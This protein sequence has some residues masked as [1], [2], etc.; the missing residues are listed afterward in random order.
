ME[1][2]AVLQP[3]LEQR[4]KLAPQ[5][6]QS[7][8]ILQ[9]PTLELME[10]VETELE[11]N[12]VLEVREVQPDPDAR[13]EAI[14]SVESARED[15][16]QYERFNDV[17]DDW[18]DYFTRSA[19]PRAAGSDDEGL[20]IIQTAAARPKT[21]HDHLIEQLQLTEIDDELRDIVEAIIYHLDADGYLRV[22]L[23]EIVDGLDDPVPMAVA[24]DALAVIQSFEPPGLG[25]RDLKEC[26]LLQLDYTDPETPFLAE[27]ITNHLKDI[28][29]NRLPA[30]AKA[31]GKSID[32]VK[33]GIERIRTLNPEPGTVF[34][35][36]PAPY[37]VPDVRVEFVDGRYQV[38]MEDGR[39]PPL[40]ISQTY[41]SMMDDQKPG[42]QAREFLKKRFDSARWLI[43]AIEQRRNTLYRVA[44]KIVEFQQEFFDKG[45]AALKPLKMQEV[46][47]E[48][49][50]HVSTVSR[51]ISHKYML[52][53][54]G[55]SD[56]RSFFSGGTT[57][58]DGNMESWEAVRQKL[59]DIVGN[60][61]KKKPLSDEEI[62]ERL[63]AQGYNIARRTV[64][65]YRKALDIPSSRQRK[66]Y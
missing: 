23:E 40:Q 43:D 49:G 22:P 34:D 59:L 39:I 53:P 63:Q 4:M 19:S 33:E 44:C 57:S 12:P 41:R 24:E 32:E 48:L 8:E 58:A 5:I 42:S 31:T 61:D 56:L 18:R 20:D 7:I 35:D 11:E 10:R 1:M 54:Q 51:A 17:A 36:A 13:K 2:R 47:E 29:G 14:D 65:K 26:L 25:A 30:I 9:L 66:E 16:D 6:I 64:T 52:S 3:R 55:V 60:E 45:P 27:L 37:I 15:S 46:A 28:E 38:V 50:I 21:I 62:A